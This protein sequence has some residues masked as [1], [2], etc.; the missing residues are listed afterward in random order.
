MVKTSLSNA[1]GPGWIPGPGTKIPHLSWPNKQKNLKHKEC[2]NKFN[3]DFKN[4]SHYKN[5]VLKKIPQNEEKEMGG[6]NKHYL[7]YH[8]SWTMLKGFF[9][10]TCWIKPPR[11]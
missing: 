3:K 9:R 10:K 7:C 4:G 11:L 8:Q 2:C 6:V 5:K 1:G